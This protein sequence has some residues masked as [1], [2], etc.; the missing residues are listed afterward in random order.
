MWSFTLVVAVA[1]ILAFAIAIAL[2]LP[3]VDN[4]VAN[5]TRLWYIYPAS[6]MHIIVVDVL[7]IFGGR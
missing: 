4:D 5:N 6:V 2:D 7:D 3:R 1:I